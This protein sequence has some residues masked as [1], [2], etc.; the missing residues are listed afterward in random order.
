MSSIPTTP[1]V[2]GRSF[3]TC[4]ALAL[5][6]TTSLGASVMMIFED[7]AVQVDPGDD[8]DTITAHYDATVAAVRRHL[9]HMPLLSDPGREIGIGDLVEPVADDHFNRIRAG[10]AGIVTHIDRGNGIIDKIVV[11]YA[12]RK[13]DYGQED[14]ET[15]RYLR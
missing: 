2:T 13:V 10:A 12:H 14:L 6:A 1:S 3:E 11:R 7:I 4:V 15:L 9:A 8:R 5:D